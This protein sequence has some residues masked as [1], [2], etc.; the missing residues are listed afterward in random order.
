M[1]G[2]SFRADWRISDLIRHARTCGAPDLGVVCADEG[3]DFDALEAQ[4][5]GALKLKPRQEPD[6]ARERGRAF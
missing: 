1:R 5:R 3:P 2:D 4:V 6:L